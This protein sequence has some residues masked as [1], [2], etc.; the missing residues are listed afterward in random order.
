MDQAQRY[1]RPWQWPHDDAG[2]EQ[3]GN[4]RCHLSLAHQVIAS[5]REKNTM[6]GTISEYVVNLSESDFYSFFLDRA[7]GASAL[8]DEALRCGSQTCGPCRA[9][10]V[11]HR[12]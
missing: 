11:T 5:R 4:C 10:P 8:A 12:D 6:T 9:N 2:K 1:R 3:H 7:F